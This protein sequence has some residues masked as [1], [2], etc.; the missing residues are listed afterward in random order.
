MNSPNHGV[1]NGSSEPGTVVRRHGQSFA[2]TGLNFITEALIMRKGFVPHKE[3]SDNHELL[4]ET[5]I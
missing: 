5:D 4:T 1:Q 2:N 3:F